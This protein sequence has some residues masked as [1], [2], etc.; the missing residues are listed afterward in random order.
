MAGFGEYAA[1]QGKLFKELMAEFMRFQNQEF[2]SML[3]LQGLMK[4]YQKEFL[5]AEKKLASKK[6]DLFKEKKI[7]KWK[8]DLQTLTAFNKEGLLKNKSLALSKMLPKVV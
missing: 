3:E 7:E 5:A 6:E 2:E 8:L 1:E 4:K